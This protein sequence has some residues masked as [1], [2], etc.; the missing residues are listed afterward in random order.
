MS[1]DG[2]GMD[3]SNSGNECDVFHVVDFALAPH[4]WVHMFKAGLTSWVS[5]SP[6]EEYFAL[7]CFY[8][9]NFSLDGVAIPG[10]EEFRDV[11]FV[12]QDPKGFLILVLFKCTMSQELLHAYAVASS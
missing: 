3:V 11:K 9:F 12:R 5:A 10:N 8:P 2:S 1:T 4:S 6:M 7:Q